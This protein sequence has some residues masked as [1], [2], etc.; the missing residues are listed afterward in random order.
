M[1]GKILDYI[2]SKNNLD[3][4]VRKKIRNFPKVRTRLVRMVVKGGS[5][6]EG[7]EKMI[8]NFITFFGCGKIKTGS[9]TLASFASVIVWFMITLFFI[10][11]EIPQ[12]YENIFWATLLGLIF[13]YSLLLIPI[14][15]ADL[16]EKDHPSIV[17]DEVVGQILALCLT[18]PFIREY[19]ID[20]SWF[21]TKII[22]FAH[23]F[24]CFILFR[25]LDI[26]KP[27]IIGWVDQNVKCSFVVM[28][29]DI[30]AGVVAAAINIAFFLF[31][32]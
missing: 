28:L 31:Y 3:E 26:A 30:I 21:L 18:Y 16:E 11:I 24:L 22:M 4:N 17:I 29:D 20:Q 7:R 14:Y 32:K 6:G 12:I 27:L 10:H 9:G 23:M 15:S 19:Y 13:L 1:F 2:A 5:I 25:V 8:K